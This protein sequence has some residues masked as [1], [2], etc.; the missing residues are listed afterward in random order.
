MIISGGTFYNY[1]PDVTKTEQDNS[2][3]GK[4]YLADGY[5]TIEEKILTG[6]TKYKVVKSN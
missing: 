6:G 4:I 3:A 1:N 5:K 2:F